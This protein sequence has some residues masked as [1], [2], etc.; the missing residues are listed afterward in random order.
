[1]STLPINKE[2][3]QLLRA[4]GETM[5]PMI[6]FCEPVVSMLN[7]ETCAVMIPLNHK[8]KNHLESMYFGALAVGADCAGGLLAM[9]HIQQSGEAVSI[10]F[11]NFTAEYLKR[12]QAD[13]LFTCVDGSPIQAGVKEAIET[14][15]RVN[16][17]LHITATVPSLLGEE[18]VA[19][20]VLTLS[21]KRIA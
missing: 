15:Q 13:V 3:T 2:A 5:V 19:K 20:F 7:D 12:P 16:V 6:N 18:P 10:V 14:Q 17:P 21:M 4:F 11:K 1:M 8:T 9:H